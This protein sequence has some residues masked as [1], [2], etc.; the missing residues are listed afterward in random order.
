MSPGRLAL[1]PETFTVVVGPTQ[2]KAGLFRGRPLTRLE[3]A[4]LTETRLPKTEG[5][6]REQPATGKA[7]ISK[8]Q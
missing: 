7:G 3:T 1:R 2:E 6:P 8:T 4:L 5:R